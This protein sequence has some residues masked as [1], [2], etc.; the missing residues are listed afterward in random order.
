M[1][2]SCSTY[3]RVCVVRLVVLVV[4]V[5]FHCVFVGLGL[6]GGVVVFVGGYVVLFVNWFVFFCVVGFLCLCVYVFV[7]VCVCVG[8]FFVVWVCD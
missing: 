1:G 2:W 8:V 5:F 4:L 6:V 7:V 3:E